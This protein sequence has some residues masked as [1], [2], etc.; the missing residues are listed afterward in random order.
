MTK[1]DRNSGKCVRCMATP[2]T[3]EEWI[4]DKRKQGLS[5]SLEEQYLGQYT[6]ESEVGLVVRQSG[7]GSVRRVFEIPTYAGGGKPV[8]FS[9]PAPYPRIGEARFPR[10]LTDQEGLE[11]DV[12]KY[13]SSIGW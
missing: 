7:N 4:Q 12:R 5:K 11:R 1:R 8:P 6:V 13:L 9:L 10:A 3:V 2:A